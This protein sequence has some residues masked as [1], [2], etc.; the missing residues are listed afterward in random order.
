MIPCY[1]GGKGMFATEKT[2][3]FKIAVILHLEATG[4]GYDTRYRY[5]RQRFPGMATVELAGMICDPVEVYDPEW[6]DYRDHNGGG[7]QEEVVLTK[8]MLLR[9]GGFR[10]EARTAIMCYDEAGFGS[11]INT[12]RFITEGKPVIGFYSRES[13]HQGV[14]LINVLQLEQEYPGLFRFMRYSSHDDIIRALTP[15]LQSLSEN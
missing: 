15:W 4:L 8:F 13:F 11:G 12:M 5:Y 1:V 9:D 6:P 14:N 3:Q 10:R 7:L 2:R